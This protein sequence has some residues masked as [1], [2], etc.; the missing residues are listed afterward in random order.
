MKGSSHSKDG[1][2]RVNG[3][4]TSVSRPCERMA[5]A[6]PVRRGCCESSTGTSSPA[7]PIGRTD[8]ISRE[9]QY[10]T[11]TTATRDKGLA[12]PGHLVVTDEV[13]FGRLLHQHAQVHLQRRVGERE[14]NAQITQNQAVGKSPGFENPIVR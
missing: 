10:T 7:Q 9:G 5:L 13:A 14:I 6:A 4:A 12:E 2:A 11:Y 8:R 1:L 3:D